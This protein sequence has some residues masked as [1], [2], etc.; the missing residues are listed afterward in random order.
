[1]GFFPC[2]LRW[3]MGS[4]FVRAR[5]TCEEKHLLCASLYNLHKIYLKQLK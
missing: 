5:I 1:M 4:D 2:E 3:R